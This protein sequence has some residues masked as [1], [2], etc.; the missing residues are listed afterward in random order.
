MSEA[1]TPLQGST[2]FKSTKHLLAE[3][4][5]A[6]GF[7][8]SMSLLYMKLSASGCPISADCA[9][10]I[11]YPELEPKKLCDF[12]ISAQCGNRESVPRYE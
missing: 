6:G 10:G 11:K 9:N 7:A 5:M 12:G 8:L 3:L 2:R 4:F 1:E